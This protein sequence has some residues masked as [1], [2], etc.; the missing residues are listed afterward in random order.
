M[1]ARR[2]EQILIIAG[3]IGLNILLGWFS[4]GSGRT[5]AAAPSGSTRARRRSLLPRLRPA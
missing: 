2:R 4:E 1:L 3:L 5:I